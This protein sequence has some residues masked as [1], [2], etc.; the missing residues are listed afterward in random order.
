MS[1]P[2]LLDPYVPNILLRHLADTPQA[3]TRTLDATLLFTDISGFTSLSERLARGGREGAEELVDALGVAFGG[4]LAV[5]YAND[6]SLLKFGGDALLLLFDGDDHL[7]RACRSASG[8]R[9]M[10]RQTGPLATSAGKVTLRMSQGMHSG[11]LHLFLVGDSH[12]ELLLAGPAATAVTHMEKAANAGEIVVSPETAA[13]LPRVWLGGQRGGGRLLTSSPKGREPGPRVLARLPSD[14]AVAGCLSTEV[15]GHVA[16]GAQPPEHRHVTAAFVRFAG[17]DALIAREGV[18][19]CA[20]ALDELMRDVTAAADEYQVCFLHTDVDADGGKIMLTA[21][22]PRMVGD[23]EERMLLA[24]RRIAER[25]RRL[26]VRIGVNR[27][28]VFCGDVGAPYRRTYA[29]MGDTVNLAAR[30]MAHAPAGALYATPGVIERSATQFVLQPVEPFAAKGKRKPVEAW[31]VGAAVGS[32]SRQ[33]VAVRFPFVGRPDELAALDEALAAVRSGQGRLVEITGETGIGKSRLIDELRQRA[34]DL[35]RL[36]VICEAYTSTTPYIAWRD[37]L[38]PLIGVAWEASDAAVVARLRE[39]VRAREPELEPWLPLLAIPFGADAP[40]TEAVAQLAPEFRRR[41]LHELVIRLLR[42]LLPGPALL[43]IEDAHQMDAAS[44]DLLA[45][46]AAELPGLP[47]LIV[48]A[49]RETGGGFRAHA[50]PA[51]MKL[52]PPGLEP[53]EALSLAEAVTDSAPVPPHVLRLAVERSGGNPQFLRDLLRAV[54]TDPYASLPDSIE[55]AAMEQVDRLA[56]AE[57]NLVR[58][59]AVLGVVFHPRHLP[60]VLDP[61][62]AEPD[63]ATWDRLSGVFTD[64]GDGYLRFRRSVIREA[65]YAG[66]PFALRRRLHAVI[67]AHLERG[68]TTE[69]EELAPILALHFARAG[70]HEKAWTYAREA[71]D[72]AAER[73]AFAD[74]AALYR[75]ALESGR[76]IGAAADQVAAA[77]ERLA[78]ALARTGELDEAHAALRAA[79]SLTAGDPVRTAEL[80]QRHALLAGRAGRVPAAVRWAT[81]GLRLLE[82]ERGQRALGCRVQIKS[83]LAGVRSR[84]GKVEEAIRLCK[85]VI[86]ECR[87]GAHHDRALAASL[88]RAFFVLDW[89]LYDAGR[90]REAVHSARA[91]E[92]YERLGDLDRQAAVLNN[93]GMFAYY[94]G[95]WQDAVALY[96][97]AAEA[98][99]RAGDAANAAFG[100]CNVGELLSDQG[101]LA[102]AETR[103][104]RAL[105]IWRGSGY[106]WGTAFVTATLGRT[107]LRAGRCGEGLELLQEA[108]RTFRR[109]HAAPDAALVAAY[110][111]EGWAFARDA[112][113]ALREADRALRHAGRMAPLLHRVRAYALAQLG[114]RGGA[115]HALEASLREAEATDSAYELALTLYTLEVLQGRGAATGAGRRRREIMAR[116]DVVALPAPPLNGEPRDRPREAAPG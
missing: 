116:L 32:R 59:A 103:L 108:E 79:R 50:G 36:R 70:I 53:D 52:A 45:A 15:R 73:L 21:G 85:S 44:A 115:E 82:G 112:R 113:R 110:L 10:L 88:A 34:A 101:R 109:L 80:L 4:L 106:E 100:A 77:W 111:A 96:E 18:E 66:L 99:D 87:G 48:T 81:R 104:R 63:A 1:A 55:T 60:H 19:A 57:R 105:R 90:P 30:V 2:R 95:R 93:L 11:E 54:H 39:L 9:R 58:R 31:S 33:G 49:R 47:W 38:R 89:A 43:E 3:P 37:L 114:D 94:Q 6:G 64:L 65:A 14:E 97:R 41:R 75:R 23:D 67:G 5:A 51:V 56:P 72:N 20:E 98:S 17:T 26:P 71:G 62:A 13:R 29:V 74:A 68:R 27:G 24:L 25:E 107:A 40:P 12:R 42:R 84:Q 92:I 16:G 28:T 102:E 8:M 22:A 86:A 69:A 91:L 83:E 35:S 76:A 46:A 7:E 61:G 78:D